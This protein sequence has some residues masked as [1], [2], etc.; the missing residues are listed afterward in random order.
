MSYF[1]DVED[2]RLIE[3]GDDGADELDDELDERT[4]VSSSRRALIHTDSD[5]KTSSTKQLI[6]LEWAAISGL[7]CR[8][9]D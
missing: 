2:Q 1:E 6:G 9:V 3:S 8:S 7:Y 4:R 5:R